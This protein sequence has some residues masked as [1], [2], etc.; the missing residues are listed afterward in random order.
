MNVTYSLL[1]DQLGASILGVN[2][3]T[4]GDTSLALLFFQRKFYIIILFMN[5]ISLKKCPK[6]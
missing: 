5:K 4:L 2:E 3:H 1:T 6:E